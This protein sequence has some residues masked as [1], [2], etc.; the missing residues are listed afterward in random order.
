MNFLYFKKL[1]FVLIMTCL[2]QSLFSKETIVITGSSTI[3]PV[4]SDIAKK[5][6][7]LNKSIRIDIQTGGSSRGISDV[8]N[9]LA[10]IDRKSVV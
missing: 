3:A 2:S 6:E 1:V 10:H 9:K 8:K 5:Y 4:V 7:A